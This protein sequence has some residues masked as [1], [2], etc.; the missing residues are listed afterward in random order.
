MNKDRKNEYKLYLEW[1]RYK[2]KQAER[3]HEINKEE[4]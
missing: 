4:K 2:L 1:L 3:Y